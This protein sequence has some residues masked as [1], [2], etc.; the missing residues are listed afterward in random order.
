MKTHTLSSVKAGITRL[1]TKGGASP[2]SLYDLLNGYVTAQRTIVIRPGSLI[3][4]LLP[5]GTKGLCAFD[6]KILYFATEVVS[7]ADPRFQCA[8][9]AHP[10]DQTQGLKEIAFAEPYA[11]APY[12]VAEFDNGDVFHYWLEATRTWAASTV[13]LEGQLVQPTTE[14]GLAYKATRQSSVNP[15]WAPSIPV[16]VGYK[17]EPAVYNGFYYEVESVTGT[18]VITG[19]TEPVWPT[20][21]GQTVIESADTASVTPT[22]PSEPGGPGFAGGTDEDPFTGII[23]NIDP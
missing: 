19:D 4:T 2:E 12:V 21:E 22:V 15:A 1:R 3:E 13:Y 7:I 10:T 20:N 16:T 11:G 6:G 9:I 5:A 17:I 14:N 8:V 23:R 18:N